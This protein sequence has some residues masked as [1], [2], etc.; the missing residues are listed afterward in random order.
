MHLG[1]RPARAIY[2]EA[3]LEQAKSLIEDGVPV[4]PLPFQPKRKVS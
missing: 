1:D 3:N 2:G 4:V